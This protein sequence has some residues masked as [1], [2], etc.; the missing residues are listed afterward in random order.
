[1]SEPICTDLLLTIEEEARRLSRFVANLFDMSHIESGLFHLRREWV[2][3]ADVAQGA[4][5][6]A[7]KSFPDREIKL[8]LAPEL[9]L[10]RGDAVLFEQVIFNLLDNADKY[11]PKDKQTR[12]EIV[13]S[14]GEA[15][16]AV[17]DDG[18][19]IPP[20]ELERVF[21]KFYRVAPGDGRPPGTG[22]GLAIARG[23]VEAMGGTIHAESQTSNGAGTRIIIRVPATETPD[24]DASAELEGE[25]QSGDQSKSPG[26]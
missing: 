3:I 10:I 24:L 15:I 11:A 4:I 21:E 22:L 2:D 8:T 23:V 13:T 14:G 16:L 18:L 5:S 20:E 19:G 7:R 9:P 6:R 12:V 17:E 25:A 26:Y 1:M